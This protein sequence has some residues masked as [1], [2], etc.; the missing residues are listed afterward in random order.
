MPLLRFRLQW[1]PVS[2]FFLE[3]PHNG[4]WTLAL[5]PR[6]SRRMCVT[7]WLQGWQAGDGQSFHRI[8][9]A[10][11]NKQ[12]GARGYLWMSSRWRPGWGRL[13]AHV[14]GQQEKGTLLVL[15]PEFVVLMHWLRGEE[16]EQTAKQEHRGS[17]A[18]S[19][20]FLWSGRGQ[21]CRLTEGVGSWQ[22]PSPYRLLAYCLPEALVNHSLEVK[23]ISTFPIPKVL[24]C[25]W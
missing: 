22:C 23:G 5:G 7:V 24:Y 9:G 13:S 11:W 19:E 10:A 2:Y 21:G 1:A 3:W 8:P 12:R 17:W 14:S 4:R 18:R 25:L 15:R 16:G 6:S 20:H